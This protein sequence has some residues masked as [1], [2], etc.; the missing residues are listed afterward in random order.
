MFGYS[1]FEIDDERFFERSTTIFIIDL[2]EV[3]HMR[4]NTRHTVRPRPVSFALPDMEDWISDDIIFVGKSSPPP[5]ETVASREVH[6]YIDAQVDVE[7]NTTIL[8][9]WKRNEMFYPHVSTL[10][11]RYLPIPASS[12]PSERVFGFTGNLVNKKRA[13]L[14]PDNVK[15]FVFMNKNMKYYW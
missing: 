7:E 10:A 4:L 1:R 6:H 2:V 15:M 8:S 5:L 14:N 12:V 9:W 13:R 11:K 3:Y